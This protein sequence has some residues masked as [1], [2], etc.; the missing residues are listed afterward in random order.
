MGAKTE[1]NL[2]RLTTATTFNMLYQYLLPLLI[3]L[4]DSSTV[5]FRNSLP[6]FLLG[7]VLGLNPG[8]W[9]FCM[10]FECSTCACIGFL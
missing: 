5:A 2:Y 1:A 8:L 9:S 3:E 6:Y 4:L 7:L 10:G